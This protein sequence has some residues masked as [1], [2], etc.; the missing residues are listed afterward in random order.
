MIVKSV[1]MAERA[2]TRPNRG[3]PPVRLIDELSA[4][5]VRNPALNRPPGSASPPPR[6]V[7]P[8]FIPPLPA[9]LFPH[10]PPQLPQG[11][12]GPRLVAPGLQDIQHGGRHAAQLA[13]GRHA[14]QLAGRE[15]EWDLQQIAAVQGDQA[16]AGADDEPDQGGNGQE[17]FDLRGR[18]QPQVPRAA[19]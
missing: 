9:Q 3:V 5:P 13:G 4:T 18:T 12:A 16:A 7:E 19:G 1:N 11:G 17:M 10:S 8:V 2:S 14:A 15:A 6:P